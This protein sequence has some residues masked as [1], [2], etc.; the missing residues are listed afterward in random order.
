MYSTAEDL[1]KLHLA[2]SEGKLVNEE[3][4]R[5]MY[6][7]YPEYNYSGYSVWTYPYPYSSTTPLI[8][9]RR[10]SIL[11]AQSVIVRFLDTKDCIVILNHNGQFNPDSFGDPEN[12]KEKIIQLMYP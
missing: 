11:G 9:E 2:L 7:S 1:L 5:M 3:S 12:L 10:G 4:Q 6:K 8:M